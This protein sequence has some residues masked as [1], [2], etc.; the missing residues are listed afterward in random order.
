MPKDHMPKDDIEPAVESQTNQG[1]VLDAENILSMPSTEDAQEEIVVSVEDGL[2]AEVVETKDRLLRLAAEFENYKKISQRE[3]QNNLKFANETLISNLLPVMDN[4]DQA[5]VAAKKSADST[6]NDVIIGVEMVLKQM[7]ETLKK[8]GVE[9]FS[10][11]GL[12]F[13]PARHEAMGEQLDEN[14]EAGSVLI[15]Y[16]KG[17][18]L[19]GRLLRPARV[20][21]AK[22]SGN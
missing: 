4:L 6:S 3:L 19:H 9:V 14:A 20:I 10:A 18:L 16:Q 13:D 1:E 17:Y 21:V 7:G 2:R 8:A 15:E 5:I 22:R 11:L 12:P